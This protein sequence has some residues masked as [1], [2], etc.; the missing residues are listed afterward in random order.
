MEFTTRISFRC[1]KLKHRLQKILQI[2][3]SQAKLE[4]DACI[5][6]LC[7]D[8]GELAI[9]IAEQVPMSKVIAVDI[10]PQIIQNLNNKL[11]SKY[12]LL[13]TDTFKICQAT[14]MTICQ[15]AKLCRTR[16]DDMAIICGVG[17]DMI[18]D[19]INSL[20][21]KPQKLIL[22]SHKNPVK[23]RNYLNSSQWGIVSEHL[24]Y[25]R[26]QYY[27][28]YVM[29]RTIHEKIDVYGGEQFWIEG[30]KAKTYLDIKIKHLELKPADL[31]IIRE[32][33][34]LYEIKSKLMK[35]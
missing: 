20:Q 1:I 7:C 9:A 13:K 31:N 14:L 5:W 23:L 11:Q 28:C 17:S 29:D 16:G 22:C 30:E 18:I 6:D 19:I 27:E 34:Q 10:V 12:E 33:E 32:R 35:S 25:D 8:H 15:D 2:I 24:F 26:G 3:V 4:N 21:I